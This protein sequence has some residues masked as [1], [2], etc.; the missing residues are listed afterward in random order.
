VGF[1]CA[2]AAAPVFHCAIGYLR[3]RGDGSAALVA[4]EQAVLR[5]KVLQFLRR[6]GLDARPDAGGIAHLYERIA[7]GSTRP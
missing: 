7:E 6:Q 2:Q 5:D 4:Q 1:S 3:T